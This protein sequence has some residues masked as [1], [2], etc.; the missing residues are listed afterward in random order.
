[1][2]RMEGKMAYYEVMKRIQNIF[3]TRLEMVKVAV[4]KEGY[5][6]QHISIILP[7]I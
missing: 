6:R 4:E 3:N 2:D 1:M 5:L 7:I